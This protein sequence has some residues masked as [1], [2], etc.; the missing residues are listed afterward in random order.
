MLNQ[1]SPFRL[2]GSDLHVLVDISPAVAVLGGRVEVPTLDGKLSVK[3]PP[4]SSSG[5]RLRLKG[6]GFPDRKTGP[7]ALQAELRIAV[8]S[9]PSERETELY[10]QLLALEA[11]T[12]AETETV[13]AE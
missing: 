11:K 8:P 7:G 6:K 10:Q 4:G 3:V 2:E 12:S 13:P 5:R 1:A 9:E